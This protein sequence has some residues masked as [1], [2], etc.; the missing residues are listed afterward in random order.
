M[1]NK[2]QRFLLFSAIILTTA[3][4]VDIYATEYVSEIGT[5]E[6]SQVETEVETETELETE[7]EE[8]LQPI[9]TYEFENNRMEAAISENIIHNLTLE[10]GD[11]KKVL[12]RKDSKKNISVRALTYLPS[13]SLVNS[14]DSMCT[15]KK[16]RVEAWESSNPSVAKVSKPDADTYPVITGVA[17][18]NATIEI[19][20][21]YT[22]QDIK[23]YYKTSAVVTIQAKNRD[24]GLSPK[25][26]IRGESVT[27]TPVLMEKTYTYTDEQGKQITETKLPESITWSSSSAKASVNQG[28][29][30]GLL[31]GTAT[32]TLKYKYSFSD[33]TLTCYDKVKV[34]T[35]CYTVEGQKIYVQPSVVNDADASP[36]INAACEY[37]RDHAT[38]ENP[39]TVILEGGT[40]KLATAAVRLYS[41]TTLD[42]TDG[43]ILKFAG[44][45]GRDKST[46]ILKLGISGAYAGEADYNASAKCAGYDGFRNVKVLGGTLQSTNINKSTHVIMAHATNVL[47]EDVTLSGGAG[48]HMMEIAAIDGFTMRNC[49]FENFTGS[50]SINADAGTGRVAYGYRAGNYEALQFDV[51]AS[52]DCF[53]G[54]YMDGTPM[55]NISITGCSF[56]GVPRGI[57]IHSQ[58]LGSYHDTVDISENT[59]SNTLKEAILLLGFKNCTINNNEIV[60]CG[61]GITV[62]SISN[63]RDYVL[64]KVFEGTKDYDGEIEYDFNT[65]I[66]GNSISIKNRGKALEQAAIYVYGANLTVDKKSY[67]PSNG[68]LWGFIPKNNY[69][70]SNVRVEENDIT[71]SGWGIY[72]SDAQNCIAKNNNIVGKN[73]PAKKVYNGIYV[74][75]YSSIDEISGNVI[76]SMQGNGISVSSLSTVKGPIENNVVTK[77]A[78]CAI[79]LDN[80]KNSLTICNNT[81][82]TKSKT[83]NAVN[84]DTGK[85]NK[86][87]I[88][89]SGNKIS[90][91][92]GSK[93]SGVFVGSGT[94]TIKK[95]KIEK[96]NVGIQVV[97][98]NSSYK[99]SGNTY[100]TV[101]KKTKVE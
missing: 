67:R 61:A 40:Y 45:G 9:T 77:A 26:L 98:K 38:D 37:A 27:Y 92:S 97:K 8:V 25:T 13:G 70:I 4:P 79:K 12:M 30:T 21:S 6:E 19:I 56:D 14:S 99:Q 64:T 10:A 59:F 3:K 33:G 90:G 62:Q 94:C 47:F 83:N 11:K 55:K 63:N 100:K 101:K 81:F 66:K 73:F 84:I 16:F 46:N 24:V 69:Y 50:K 86:N 89:L 72:F 75:T 49:V 57:G 36:A 93:A 52:N 82:A 20:Y 68:S 44:V 29:V 35:N 60:D 96:V 87:R 88:T 5:G 34:T 41:N 1:K 76:T 51:V 43:A 85:N 31:Q 42:M 71:T 23:A 74:A 53:G 78:Y 2:L 32:I 22:Y 80:V 58:V 18:G 95:N 39:Y 28:T 65:E 17:E 91:V 15:F 7:P 54:I 48:M